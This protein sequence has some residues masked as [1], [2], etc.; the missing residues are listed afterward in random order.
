MA[1]GDDLTVATLSL[2]DEGVQVD[3]TLDAVRKSVIAGDVEQFLA[4][5]GDLGDKSPLVYLMDWL[6]TWQQE[7][8]AFVHVL[9]IQEGAGEEEEGQEQGDAEKDLEEMEAEAEKLMTGFGKVATALLQ[10][11]GVKNPDTVVDR[12]GWT[13]LM[14]AANSGLLELTEELIARKADVNYGGSATD[15]SNPLYLA[16]ESEHSAVAL[17]LLKNGAIESATKL[18]TTPSVGADAGDE[19]EDDDAEDDDCALFQACR[20][21]HISVIKEMLALGADVNFALPSNGD[22]ALHV[23]VMFEMQEVVELLAG[24]N[25]IDLN[26]LNE[27]GQTC[28]FGCSG[29]ELAKLLIAKG[30][31]P[32]IK[33]VDGETALSVAQALGDDEVAEYLSTVTL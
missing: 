10:R 15:T 13:L 28:L 20:F 29:L 32:K 16:V 6:H 22:R 7:Y 3:E 31:D 26:A 8:E 23:A 25:K 11:L 27:I 2:G 5:A 1:G 30:V 19:D 33:D 21:G 12:H 18:V 24:S 9:G 4:T 17:L 14:Q